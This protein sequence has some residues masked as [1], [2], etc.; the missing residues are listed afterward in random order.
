MIDISTLSK[1]YPYLSLAKQL[2][3]DYGDVLLVSDLFTP[4]TPPST[5]VT[6]HNPLRKAAYDRLGNRNRTM[7]CHV[8]CAIANGE[9]GH[10]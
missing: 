8:A 7:V 6:L 9:I 4:T 10:G 1:S 2:G 5:V 3:V